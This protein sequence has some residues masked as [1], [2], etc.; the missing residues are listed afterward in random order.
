MRRMVTLRDR[1]AWLGARR[2]GSSTVAKILGISP[3]GG[4]VDAYLEATEPAPARVARW[5][6]EVLERGREWEPVVL[7]LY[8]AQTGRAVLRP[9]PNAVWFGPE[10][11]ATATPDAF[12]DELVLDQVERGGVEAK[13]DI[14]GEYLWGPP[15]VIERWEPGCEEIVRPDYALQA[16]WQA[17]VCDLPWVDLAVLLPRY[18]LRVYRIMRDLELEAELV[19][20]VGRWWRDHVEARVMPDPGSSQAWRR[21]FARQDHGDD[22]HVASL[23]VEAL[24]HE[25]KRLSEEIKRLTEQR[26]R[27][28]N[29]LLAAVGNDRGLELPH[30]GKVT[31]VRQPGR[32]NFD[33]EAFLERRPDARPDLEACTFQGEPFAYPLVTLPKN[34]RIPARSA[35]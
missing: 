15:Q 29:V 31:A 21:W 35:A 8:Q 1:A 9:K 33:R 19:E 12:A 24:A 5:R 26:D 23:E 14:R 18:E 25:H 6:T 17:W 3:Y 13:T 4:P 11:W 32:A 20:T 22:V 2:C 34:S 28:G 16:S 27:I 10:D 7:H 30:G